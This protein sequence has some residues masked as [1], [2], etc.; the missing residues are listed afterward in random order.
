MS[1]LPLDFYNVELTPTSLLVHNYEPQD[2]FGYALVSND[3]NVFFEGKE[4]H[5]LRDLYY[6]NTIE[7]IIDQKGE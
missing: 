2:S 5:I 6:P 1:T 7:L 3:Y 4:Y